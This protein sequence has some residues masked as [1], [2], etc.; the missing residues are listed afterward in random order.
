[1]YSFPNEIHTSRAAR[2]FLT[3]RPKSGSPGVTWSG[4]IKFKRESYFNYKRTWISV[5]WLITNYYVFKNFDCIFKNLK[6]YILVNIFKLFEEEQYEYE[7]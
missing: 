5:I 1:M 3:L 7:I 6:K 4:I 2:A